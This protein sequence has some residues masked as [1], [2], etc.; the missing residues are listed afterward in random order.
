MRDMEGRPAVR[1]VTLTN[2]ADHAVTYDVSTR[3][4][5]A[6]EPPYTWDYKTVDKAGRVDLL[7]DRVTVPAHRSRTIPVV[8]REPKGAEPG[9][10]FGGWL[11]FTPRAVGSGT[12]ARVPFMGLA[13]DLDAVDAINPSFSLVNPALDN[14]ALRPARYNFGK[15]L[16]LTIDTA[17]ASTADDEAQVMISTQFPVLSRFQVQVLDASGAVVAVPYDIADMVNNAGAG[18]GIEFYAWNA[19]LGDG[20]PAPA[21][22]YRMRLVMDKY[23][24]DKDGAPPTQTWTSPEITVVR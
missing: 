17:N 3:A 21:G 10:V 16:P 14:P 23:M 22:T 19:T 9:T 15:N 2:T 7:T 4:A 20:S 6:V 18:T 13:G 8:F 5:L 24:G 12:V 11:E 1:T